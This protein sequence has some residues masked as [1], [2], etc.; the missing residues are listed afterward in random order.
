LF[1]AVVSKH[2]DIAEKISF[3][4]NAT[5][6]IVSPFDS[7]LALRGIKT[8]AVKNRSGAAQRIEN[9]PVAS[10]EQA[11]RPGLFSRLD[12]ASG[13]PDPRPSGFRARIDN[14]LQ[15]CVKKT[16]PSGNKQGPGHNLRRKF[17]RVESLIT[18]RTSQTH[19]DIPESCRKSIG[20][21]DDLV[22]LSIG[23]ENVDDLIADLDQAI[24]Q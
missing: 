4:Q 23:I 19:A 18:Y 8:L 10:K 1:G 9:S 12:N 24:G 5:G 6:A 2:K 20:I 16:C 11:C 13:S 21:T 22:R 15:V 17:R 14:F 7:W 3:T